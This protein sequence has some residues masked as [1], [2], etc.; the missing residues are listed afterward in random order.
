MRQEKVLEDLILS[1]KLI[2]RE[3]L[4]KVRSSYL[5]NPY[6]N[7]LHALKVASYILYLDPKTTS[8]TQVKSLLF[9]ALFHDA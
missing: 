2:N 9:A 8:I 6:H 5:D 1:S 7:Y 4:D 3:V